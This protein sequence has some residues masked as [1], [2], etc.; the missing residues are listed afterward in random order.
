MNQWQLQPLQD[1]FLGRTKGRPTIFKSGHV[2]LDYRYSS[3]PITKIT[4]D[5]HNELFNGMK[6]HT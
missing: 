1:I 6:F 2:K 4:K 3:P 5:I